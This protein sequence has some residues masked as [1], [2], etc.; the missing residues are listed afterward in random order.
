MIPEYEPEIQISYSSFYGELRGV[1]CI[2][3][4]EKISWDVMGSE[5]VFGNENL[6]NLVKHLTM[7]MYLVLYD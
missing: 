4:F 7:D 3:I 6:L 2:Y 1:F 5:Y